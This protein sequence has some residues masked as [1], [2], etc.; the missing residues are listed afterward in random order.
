MRRRALLLIL[1]VVI[2]LAG[3]AEW[4]IAVRTWSGK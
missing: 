3:V 1:L 4:A 2:Y